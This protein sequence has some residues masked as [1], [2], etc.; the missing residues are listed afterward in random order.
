MSGV[1]RPRIHVLAGVN[2]AGKSSIGGAAVRQA[3]GEY[4]NPDEAARALR[5]FAPAL[6]QAQANSAAWRQGVRL[7]TRAI[8]ERLD[9]TFETTLGGHTITN[10]LAQAAEQGIEVHVWYMGLSSLALHIERVQARVS[11]GGHDIPGDAVHRR[12][13]HSRLNLI[14]LLPHLT[15]LKVYDNSVDADPVAGH[16]PTPTLVLHIERGKILGPSD[17][18][19]TPDW[20]RPIVAAALR[21]SR[22]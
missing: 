10:L 11:Q 16:A 6:T 3:G 21:L 2:G 7:L 15:T 12:Y 18:T 5:E 20:A 19:P 17:L 14:S 13:E 8:D 22:P 9:F 4:F 1:R